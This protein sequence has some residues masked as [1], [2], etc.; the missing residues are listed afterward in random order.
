MLRNMR[1]KKMSGKWTGIEGEAKYFRI[2][3]DRRNRNRVIRNILV[4]FSLVF[5]ILFLI[6]YFFVGQ[7]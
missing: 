3:R 5:T 6:N 4:A 7:L 2:V 1:R